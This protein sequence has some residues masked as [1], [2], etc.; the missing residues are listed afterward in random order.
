MRCA[1]EE[2]PEARGPGTLTCCACS[3]PAIGKVFD[4]HEVADP[5]G[6][7]RWVQSAEPRGF[8]ERHEE[9]CSCCRWIDRRQQVHESPPEGR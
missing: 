3:R 7:W 2:K 4:M 1:M 5:A 8:C 6:G 9:K